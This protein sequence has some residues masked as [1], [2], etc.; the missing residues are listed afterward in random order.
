MRPSTRSRTE[1]QYDSRCGYRGYS[2][3]LEE[4]QHVVLLGDPKVAL[5][6]RSP[7]LASKSC[8]PFRVMLSRVSQRA[9]CTR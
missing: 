2:R 5:F 7:N 1:Q 3:S 6:F 8:V 9:T 4:R